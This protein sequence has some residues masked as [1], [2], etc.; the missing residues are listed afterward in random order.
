MW[1]QAVLQQPGNPPLASDCSIILRF[2]NQT[3]GNVVVGSTFAALQSAGA[4]G[5]SGAAT[6]GVATVGGGL[7]AGLM[8]AA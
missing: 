2:I 8:R 5:M 3:A 7:G 1:L 6:V 4:A